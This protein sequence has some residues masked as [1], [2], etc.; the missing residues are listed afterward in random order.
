MY[1]LPVLSAFPVIFLSPFSSNTSSVRLRLVVLGGRQSVLLVCD[2]IV[3]LGLV[4][5]HI[6]APSLRGSARGTQDL[7]YF[8]CL[9]LSR[10]WFH[11]ALRVL[12]SGYKPLQVVY[13]LSRVV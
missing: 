3:T 5:V 4:W 11:A 12:V 6:F 13:P 2:P 8:V 10:L 1:P 9:V 7:L